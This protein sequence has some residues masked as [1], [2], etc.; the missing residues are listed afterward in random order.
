MSAF[1]TS[2]SDLPRFS[3]NNSDDET[4]CCF[5]QLCTNTITPNAVIRV[6]CSLRPLGA[7]S[8]D[9]ACRIQPLRYTIPCSD[10]NTCCIDN[11][12][13]SP[14]PTDGF[15]RRLPGLAMCGTYQW[16][17]LCCQWPFH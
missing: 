7:L 10:R 14:R 12:L 4:R 6:R 15:R 1:S 8:V 5:Q 9:Y 16:V 17:T 13:G 11:E 3:L 2:T